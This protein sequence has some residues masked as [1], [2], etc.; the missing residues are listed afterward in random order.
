MNM[1][2]KRTMGQYFQVKDE[3]PRVSDEHYKSMSDQEKREYLLQ[4][5][6]EETMKWQLMSA[7]IHVYFFWISLIVG[8]IS[9][10]ILYD[11]DMMEATSSIY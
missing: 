4:L 8:I 3:L 2:T 1:D 11:K 7:K 5:K 10:F 9:L 6:Q